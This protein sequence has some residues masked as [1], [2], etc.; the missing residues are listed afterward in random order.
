M[1]S[2]RFG[3]PVGMLDVHSM[4]VVGVLQL[5]ADDVD[6]VFFGRSVDDRFAE[7]GFNVCDAVGFHG[8]GGKETEKSIGRQGR[9]TPTKSPFVEMC[10]GDSP[11]RLV[12]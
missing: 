4:V 7:N 9:S 3:G 11:R 12:C 6:R 8:L 5:L 2:R 1:L 10:F